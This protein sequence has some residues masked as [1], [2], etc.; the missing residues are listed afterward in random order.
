MNKFKKGDTVDIV[1][2]H[3]FLINPFQ[4]YIIRKGTQVIILESNEDHYI[5]RNRGIDFI[6]DLKT[7][8][9][10]A[11]FEEPILKR[12][13]KIIETGLSYGQA[14]DMLLLHGKKV[15]RKAW[16]GYWTVQTVGNIDGISTSWSGRFIVA[17]LKNGGNAIASPYQ[18]DMFANDWMVV[19]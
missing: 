19:E 10:I 5:I 16:D 1:K 12:Y 7:F 8:E 13:S 15:T 17:Y 6:L 4:R 3:E 18:E 9:S 14:M 2:D 11:K